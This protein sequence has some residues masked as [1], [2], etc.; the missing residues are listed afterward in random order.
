MRAA[1]EAQERL[2]SHRP[3][4]GTLPSAGPSPYKTPRRVF[5]LRG[6]VLFIA[7]K[8]PGGAKIAFPQGKAISA[9]LSI[10]PF[11][12]GSDGFSQGRHGPES[13]VMAVSGGAY[14]DEQGSR[15]Q[16]LVIPLVRE[17]QFPAQ[18][19]AFLLQNRL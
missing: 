9:S 17:V 5:P 19:G 3:Q 2:I 8:S 1:E 15:G 14:F 7:G 16:I 11:G 13:L 18:A 4:R 6:V 10:R 12:Q